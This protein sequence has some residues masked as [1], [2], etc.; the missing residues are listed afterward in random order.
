MSTTTRTRKH[1]P[2]NGIRTNG[3]PTETQSVAGW[4][5]AM[6]IYA[7]MSLSPAALA[8]QS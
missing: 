7:L 2:L 3:G 6:R 1:R 8:V 5:E 4:W